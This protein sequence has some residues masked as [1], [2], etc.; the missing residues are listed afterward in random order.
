MPH[1]NIQFVEVGKVLVTALPVNGICNVSKA[2]VAIFAPR[3]RN[4]IATGEIPSHDVDGA[5]IGTRLRLDVRRFR[6]GCRRGL[7][8]FFAAFVQRIPLGARGRASIFVN[9]PSADQ[10]LLQ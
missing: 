2:S 8:C 1:D 10:L 5:L 6:S 4:E 7:F 3:V 9:S